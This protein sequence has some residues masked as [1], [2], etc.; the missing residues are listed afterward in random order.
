MASK[1]DKDDKASTG[2]VVVSSEKKARKPRVPRG[3]VVRLVVEY[4]VKAQRL[5]A[6]YQ[7]NVERFL[8]D[9]LEKVI[10]LNSARV[11]KL[12]ESVRM[13]SVVTERPV[14]CERRER[15]EVFER[16]ND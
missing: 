5:A 10:E 15:E 4:K 8:A 11:E 2:G 16:A 12:L 14:L 7:C 1:N 3:L 9:Q 6:V 13:E